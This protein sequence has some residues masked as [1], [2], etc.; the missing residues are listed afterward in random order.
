MKEM[1]ERIR[2]LAEQAGFYVALFD[3]ENKDNAM[4][5]KFAELIIDECCLKLIDMQ[6]NARG[7][8]NYYGHAA[9]QIKQHFKDKV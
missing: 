3:V 1:N 8:H 7:M 9:L 4:I 2:D 6:Y 5:E